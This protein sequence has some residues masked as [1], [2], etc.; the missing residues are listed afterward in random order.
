[1]LTFLYVIRDLLDN[2]NNSITNCIFYFT[3]KSNQP[4]KA[5]NYSRNMSLNEKI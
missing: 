4:E 5:R 1:M 2:N 3:K